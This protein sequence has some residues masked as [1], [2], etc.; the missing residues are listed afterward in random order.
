MGSTVYIRM[1]M[2]VSTGG[3]SLAKTCMYECVLTSPYCV[4]EIFLVAKVKCFNGKLPSVF[5]PFEVL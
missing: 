5:Q 2:N 3:I 1:C 4:S